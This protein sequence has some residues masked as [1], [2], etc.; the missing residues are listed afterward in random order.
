MVFWERRI[1]IQVFTWKVRKSGALHNASTGR[2][3]HQGND[4]F[5]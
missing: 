2:P 1:L 5:W 4:Y 3:C